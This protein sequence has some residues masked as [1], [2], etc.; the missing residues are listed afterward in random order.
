LGW[1][2][3][4][5]LER[6]RPKCYSPTIIQYRNL[7]SRQKKIHTTNQIKSNQI[8]KRNMTQ[9][10]NTSNTTSID[11]A[12][13]IACQ[14]LQR[15]RECWHQQYQVGQDELKFP[16]RNTRVQRVTKRVK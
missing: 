12:I 8:I 10:M 13:A 2:I 14:E 11:D 15:L 4:S 3:H 1:A 6:I 7:L 16:V 9:N 5:L